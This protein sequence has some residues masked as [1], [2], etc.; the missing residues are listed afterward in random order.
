M[1]DV[2]WQFLFYSLATLSDV[3]IKLT[4]IYRSRSED[5]VRNNAVAEAAKVF[6]TLC[7]MCFLLMCVTY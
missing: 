6:L 2:S 4:S 5:F 7:Y 1:T 3:Q